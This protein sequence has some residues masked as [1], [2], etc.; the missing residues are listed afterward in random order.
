MMKNQILP[1]VKNGV[2]VNLK[3]KINLNS[4]LKEKNILLKRNKKDLNKILFESLKELKL[5]NKDK[6]KF[7]VSLN[8]FNSKKVHQYNKDYR[9][10]DRT[11]DVLSFPQN[12]LFK[13]I[14]DLGDVIING[15]ILKEQSKKNSWSEDEELKFLFM[16]GL[17]HIIGYRHDSENEEKLM[18]NLQIKIFNKIGININND[19]LI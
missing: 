18:N 19:W 9:N 4:E 1:I 7:V 15:E 10:V 12:E 2:D 8:I 3:Y 6:I 16:H 14:Y 5:N 13:N 17:L 11:T